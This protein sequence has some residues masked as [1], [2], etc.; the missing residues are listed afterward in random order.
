MALLLLILMSI[1]GLGMVMAVNSDML[2][3]GYYSNYRSSYYAADSGLNIARQTLA[4][5]LTAQVNQAAC[6]SWGNAT[7]SGGLCSTYPLGNTSTTAPTAAATAALNALI[8]SY[9]NAFTALSNGGSASS[10]PGS[11]EISSSGTNTSTLVPTSWPT[12][13][14]GSTPVCT[15]VFK[16]NLY[17]LGKGPGLQQVITSE[18]GFLTI[19]ITA[20]TPTNGQASN[21]VKFSSFG[22]FIGNFPANDAPLVPGTITG[23]QFTNGSW[24]FGTGGY[25]FSD[26]VS[27]AGPTVSYYFGGNTWVDTSAAS[28]K[29]GNTTIAPNFEGGLN[30]GVAAAALPADDFSQQWA[31]LD[32]MGC[33][34]GSNVCGNSSSPDP[35]AMTA[36]TLNQYGLQTANQ[37]PY[38]ANGETSG[39]YMPYSCTKTTCTLKGG[40][41]Y[42]EG[43]VT[44]ILLTPGSAAGTQIYTIVQNGTTT[45][46]TTNI[47]ANTTTMV[48][49]S[50]TTVINGVP[51]S[52]VTGTAVP[53]TLLYVDGNLGGIVSGS[54]NNANYSGLS[55]PGEGMAAIQ[56]GV[57]LTVVANGDLNVTGDLRYEQEPVTLTT[58]DTLIP[59]NNQGQVLGLFTQ[60]GN[61]VLNSTYNDNNLEIDAAMAALGNN[62]TSNTCGLETPGNGINTLTIVGGRMEAY[63]HGVDL[64]AS[65]TY[66]DRR[67][68]TPGFGPPYFPS[69]VV[70][71][72]V[73][74]SVPSAPVVGTP[75]FS[76]LSWY[77]SPQTQ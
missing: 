23:P 59:A 24:N 76:R 19:N 45:T 57:A 11:F 4:N 10:W 27:Q 38:S 42:V 47:S 65:N 48:S 75:T 70:S 49:G 44:S 30:V 26:T 61:L 21:S 40:G 28:A 2:I 5:D 8:A 58:A 3:N 18:A 29:S 6:L 25:I 67:F 62:C 17:A 33:G 7:A 9:G 34:E 73:I 56:N 51:E 41:I 52:M 35:P 20:G 74:P 68:L 46:I 55:G 14:C 71:Q 31:V 66:F 72:N 69:T 12:G 32:G 13:V 53:Q 43:N 22:A 77:T 50:T 63:V 16:Y 64:G 54:G 37:T 1:L 36:A 60:S 15:Y 39:V